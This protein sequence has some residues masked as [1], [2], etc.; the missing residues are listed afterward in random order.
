M[1]IEDKLK[2]IK[3]KAVIM[4]IDALKTYTDEERL[5]IFSEFCDHCGCEDPKCQCWNDE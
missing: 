5:E 4:M 2:D 3:K 1:T